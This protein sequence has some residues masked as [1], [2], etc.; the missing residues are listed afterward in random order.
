M[1]KTQTADIN[2]PIPRQ[3]YA[4]PV[5]NVLNALV[6][7]AGARA[8]HRAHGTRNMAYIHA[9]AITQHTSHIKKAVVSHGAW[10]NQTVKTA[11]PLFYRA[12]NGFAP[13]PAA[14]RPERA[15]PAYAEP[16]QHYVAQFDKIPRP[17]WGAILF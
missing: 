15:H 3:N 7:V 1:A 14:T 6:N 10:K 5:V 12:E 8:K 2:Q 17:M 13:H 16:G 4:M 11:K 9:V